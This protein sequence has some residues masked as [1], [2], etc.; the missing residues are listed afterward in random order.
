M[1]A[2]TVLKV[3]DKRD[4][5]CPICLQKF[6]DP[7]ELECDHIYCLR[8]LQDLMKKHGKI[9]CPKCRQMHDIK[10]DELKSMKSNETLSNL[11]E[12]VDKIES[13]QPEICSS[14]NNQPKHH[15]SECEMYLCWQCIQQHKKFPALK[16]HS[17]YTLDTNI[18]ED[19]QDSLKCKNHVDKKLEDYCLICNLT[20]CEDCKHIVCCYRNKHEVI[21][22]QTALNYINLTVTETMEIAENVREKL[23]ERL[24]V[25]TKNRTE[26][27][28][29]LKLS[30]TVIE[31]HECTI[32]RKVKEES[33]VMME[34]L[35]QIY[36]EQSKVINIHVENIESKLTQVNSLMS[37]INKMMNKPTET[38]NLAL[39]QTTI[40]AVG[41]EVAADELDKS[42]TKTRITPKFIPSPKLAELINHEGVGKL[43]TVGGVH[44]VNK[45]INVKVNKK[46][47]N[48]S[49]T[50]GQPFSVKVSSLAESDVG[51][52]KVTLT[53]KLG[54]KSAT[55]QVNR[56]EKYTITGRCNLEG[57]WQMDI[58]DGVMSHVICSP[59]SIKVQPLGHVHTID[60]IS[61]YK[62]HDKN[63]NNVTNVVLDTDRCM[64]VSGYSRELIKFD[65]S[66]CFV[67]RLQLPQNVSAPYMHHIGNGHMVY[68]DRVNICVVMCDNQYQ[69]IQ[70]FGK[71]V[72]KLPLGVIVNQETRILYVADRKCHCVFKFNIDD[73]SLLGKIDSEGSKA[74]QMK[75]PEDVAVTKDG[76]LIVADKA[77]N[78]LQIFDVNGKLRKILV[79]SG[80]EDGKVWTPYGLTI[81]MD[82]NIIV[83]SMN[84]LQLFDQNGKFIK[85]IDKED[86]GLN[87]PVGIAVISNR[88][89]RVAVANH[90]AQNVKIFNY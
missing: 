12:C 46:D 78:R 5:E 85:R 55:L 3:F 42:F 70:T 16:N 24:D 48:I 44:Q 89:R 77:N 29:S 62:E 84:K 6:T 21:P 74:G 87:Y 31:I 23:K 83:S 76:H 22:M 28:S 10:I 66:G 11:V 36:E 38:E 80:K 37:S 50:K 81:D 52:L 58:T 56:K 63:K 33:K 18:E 72:L 9:Q 53:H 45:L 41:N 65:Q 14:C 13:E 32:I 90:G 71:G 40:T 67:S 49:V 39:Y 60:N 64:L 88:P 35:T 34:N 68:T 1:S 59:V 75:E 51:Q 15:C 54:A 61:E 25:I 26:L 57:D 73:G 17:L 20:A 19:S 47:E 8:C 7:K 79:G 4:L 82:D 69:A 2:K 30:R 43:I 86:D 27:E